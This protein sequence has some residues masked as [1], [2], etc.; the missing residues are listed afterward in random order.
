MFL[1]IT[2]H[3]RKVEKG[4]RKFSTKFWLPKYTVFESTNQ[5]VDAYIIDFCAST[6]TAQILMS[7]KPVF[8]LNPGYPKLFEDAKASLERC[9]ILDMW[10]CDKFR[11][12]VD[13]KLFEELINRKQHKYNND[14]V[15]SHYAGIQIKKNKIW[16]GSGSIGFARGLLR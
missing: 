11:L 16:K 14:F 9:Y 15:A 5:E 13:W 2:N 8:F 3:I 6:T 12:H 10:F 1:P 7:N 4:T